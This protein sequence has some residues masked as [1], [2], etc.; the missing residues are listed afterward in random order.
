[1]AKTLS[2]M[3]DLGTPAPDF[4]LPDP[5]GK[6]YGLDDFKNAPVLVMMFLC[7]HC[8][9]VIHVREQLSELVKEYQRK[10]AA[11]VGISSNDVEHYPDDRPEK[12]AEIAEQC[13]FS[14][15]Y[16]YDE[17]QD[18]AKAYEAACTPDF[19]IYDHRRHLVYRGQMDNARPGN[20]EL[21]DGRDLRMALDLALKGQQINGPQKPSMG[22]NIK[23]KKG[24][25]PSYFR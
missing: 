20:D 14:F 10:G 16:L 15:P 12:M 1:M 11:F 7:N 18:V 24:A 23:W 3:K 6:V 19:F 2:T 5:S 13:G 22:C 8:P 21:N 17:S 9:Y 4:K 25:E